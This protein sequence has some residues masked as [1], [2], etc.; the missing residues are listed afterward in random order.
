MPDGDNDEVVK[1]VPDTEGK[2]TPGA[3][4]KY[5]EVVPW[6]KYVGV[7]E[8]LGKRATEA[9]GKVTSLEAQLKGVISTEDFGKV[10]NELEQAQGQLQTTKTELDAVKEKSLSEKRDILTKKGVPAEKA[11][12]MSDGELNAAILMLEHTKPGPD[13]GGGGGASPLTGKSPMD[14]AVQAYTTKP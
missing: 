12:E 5:P 7:K 9:E 11:K 6:S 2:I 8:S 14:L 13:L 1:I 3:D 4:G 10:W